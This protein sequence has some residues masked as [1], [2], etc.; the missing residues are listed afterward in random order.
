MDDLISKITSRTKAI[1]LI[2][3]HGNSSDI[4]KIK[5]IEKKKKYIFKKDNF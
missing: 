1:M 2:N 4:F 5:K 3:I